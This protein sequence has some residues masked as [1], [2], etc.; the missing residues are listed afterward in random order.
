MDGET[1]AEE[2]S[3]L[4]RRDQHHA[5][6]RAPS[7]RA[8]RLLPELTAPEGLP[9]KKWTLGCREQGCLPGSGLLL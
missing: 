6:V 1:Q 7:Y 2:H 4:T 9:A 5:N 3:H 8:V